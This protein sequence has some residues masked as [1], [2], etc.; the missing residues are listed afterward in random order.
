MLGAE[1][2]VI[3]HPPVFKIFDLAQIAVGF[4]D[5]RRP[6]RCL[7]MSALPQKQTLELS[8]VMSA[9]CQKRTFCTAAD[10]PI[11]LMAERFWVVRLPCNGKI[12]F[13]SV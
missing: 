9:L 12:N 8:R 2:Q 1:D 5:E 7:L 11:H 4:R 3:A 13:S 6:A 10:N